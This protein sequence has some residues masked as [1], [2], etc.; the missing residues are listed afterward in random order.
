MS[1]V[2]FKAVDSYS[3][4]EEISDAASE[5]LKELVEKENISL[6][7]FIPLKV[8]FGEKG[9]KTFIKSENYAGVINYL[10]EK[11]IESAFIETNVLY[12]GE[13]TTREKHINLA[14][15][16]GFT[17]LPIIIAD[18]EHGEEFE[19]VEINKKHFNKCKIGKEI[20][21]KKQ[22]IIMSHFKGHALAG[23]GGAI[24]QLGMGCASRGGK[25]AQHANSIPKISSLKCKA[26]NACAKK[27][28]EGAITVERKAKIDKDKCIGC[29]SCMAICPHKAISNSW[30]ASISKSFNERLSEY[31]YGAAKDKNNIYITFA[32]NITRNCDC[33]GHSM[34]PIVDDV[35]VFASTD[36]VAIDKACLD[37]IDRNNNKTVFRRG[38]ATL[39]YAEKIGLGSTEYE[40]I[41]INPRRFIH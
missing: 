19:D 16:H 27:C 40:L 18:G 3:K 9:N 4:T 17:E 10:K 5:L 41:E 24:K 38:R 14:K 23:F 36:P 6:E 37:V 26:C 29:A 13:R 25:L 7:S 31:A 22:L 39:D 8:H 21:N 32:F 11:N 30:L 2:Y 1:N 28:P 34:K 20:A 15:E 12:R 35:G 33:E